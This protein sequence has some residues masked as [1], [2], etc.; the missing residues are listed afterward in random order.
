MLAARFLPAPSAYGALTERPPE[1]LLLYV[2]TKKLTGSLIFTG[3]NANPVAVVAVEQGNVRKVRTQQAAH[4]GGI[5]YE[6]GHIDAEALNRTLAQVS[7]SKTPHGR[8]LRQQGLIDDAALA[9]G[10]VEQIE[11]KVAALIA[12][13]RDTTW[14]FHDEV[15]ALAGY[16]GDDWPSVDSLGS[17]WR[18]LR[19][20]PY[21]EAIELA[22][23]RARCMH[24]ALKSGA[25]ATLTRLSEA[26]A[27]LVRAF[28]DGAIYD[29]IIC[30]LSDNAKTRLF[31]FLLLAGALEQTAPRKPSQ[32]IEVPRV[33]VSTPPLVSTPI[34]GTPAVQPPQHPSFRM[35]APLRPSRPNIAA[36]G[37]HARA[38]D[39]APASSRS[40]AGAPIHAPPRDPRQAI[41]D[42]FDSLGQLDHF[43]LLGVTHGA[44]MDEVRAQFFR[45]SRQ[46]HPDKQPRDLADLEEKCTRITARLIDAYRVLS[47]VKVRASYI[48]ER[49]SLAPPA[50]RKNESPKELAQLALR[51]MLRSFT[52]AMEIIDRAKGADTGED[53]EVATIHAWVVAQ[54][55]ARQDPEALKESV[56][57]FDRL[58]RECTDN[59]DAYYY[60]A[61][62]H[63][64]LGQAT[65]A[66]KDLKTAAEYDADHTDASRE[67]RLFRMRTEGGMAPEEALGMSPTAKRSESLSRLVAVV[68][69]KKD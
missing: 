56:L 55:P 9:Q 1:H 11:R 31:Y 23:V 43:A 49:A 6:L 64:R 68:M 45:M 28:R 20:S 67:L 62:L 44:S 7:T 61:Q 12:L 13:P 60:R 40:P 52:E 42:L 32:E 17:V 38:P 54:D 21:F 5:L 3:S 41:D 15:D 69:G 2:R 48:A 18:G 24:L 47:D 53:P 25:E 34:R 30:E 63:K 51:V 66:L 26:E 22:S 19:E 59:A 50:S 16:G 4:L 36:S 29:D 58:T 37:M 46:F 14:A 8:V 27:G 33:T 65:H 57:V 35:P 10:L 39:S